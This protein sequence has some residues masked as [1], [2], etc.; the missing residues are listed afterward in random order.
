[1]IDAEIKRSQDTADSVNDRISTIDSKLEAAFKPIIS[2]GKAKHIHQLMDFTQNV[3]SANS[4]S[5]LQV[6]NHATEE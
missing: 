4:D 5:K 2:R 1:M 6:V 3:S